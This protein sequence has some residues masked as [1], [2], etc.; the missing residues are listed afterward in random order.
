MTF[1][2]RLESAS[3]SSSS[4]R[5]KSGGQNP[6]RLL[7]CK[8]ASTRFR[9]MCYILFLSHFRYCAPLYFIL[10]YLLD[11]EGGSQS[12]TLVVLV[13]VVVISSLK[14]PPKAFLIRSAAQRNFAY[15]FVLT[16]LTDQ[17]SPIFKLV[18]N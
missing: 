9:S 17:P 1:L 12:T 4:N 13:V 6:Q 10:L 3:S 18:S 2:N 16:F 7:R 5:D 11:P 14:N 15:T 8:N